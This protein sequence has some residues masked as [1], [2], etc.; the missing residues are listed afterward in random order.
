M[1]FETVRPN[2]YFQP[3]D[4]KPGGPID[5]SRVTEIALAPQSSGSGHFV[6]SRIAVVK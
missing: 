1:A 3:P 4:A 6:F 2:P 5:L